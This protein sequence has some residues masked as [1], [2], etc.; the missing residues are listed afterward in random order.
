MDA[1]RH[2]DPSDTPPLGS[3]WQWSGRVQAWIRGS[4]D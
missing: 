1:V 3:P 4:E 2:L